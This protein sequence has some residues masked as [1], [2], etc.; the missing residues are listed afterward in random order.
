MNRIP[1]ACT[2]PDSDQ[3]KRQ[4]ELQDQLASGVEERVEIEDGIALR[5]PSDA[6]WIRELAE[7]IV[8]ERACCPFLTLELAAE[9]DQG[10]V[11]LKLR[12]PEGTKAFLRRSLALC[13]SARRC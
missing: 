7:L 6:K 9:P 4:L 8:F 11:W 2:L 12:G 3:E 5:F 13:D 10:P 1:I